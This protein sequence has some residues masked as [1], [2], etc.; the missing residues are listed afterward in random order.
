MG[1]VFPFTSA[2]CFEIFW[3]RTPLHVPQRGSWRTSR[4]FNSDT[5]HIVTF[6]SALEAE[7]GMEGRG[8]EEGGLAG[9]CGSFGPPAPLVMM[10]SSPAVAGGSPQMP[11]GVVAPTTS[12]QLCPSPPLASIMYTCCSKDW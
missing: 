8:Q 2:L 6:R 12:Q 7:E 10:T 3:A 4:G 5:G 9:V 11:A 1:S